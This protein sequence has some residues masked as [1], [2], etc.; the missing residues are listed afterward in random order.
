M[1]WK[2]KGK[3]EREVSFVG[4]PDG[5]LDLRM[6]RKIKEFPWHILRLEVDGT[7]SRYPGVDRIMISSKPTPKAV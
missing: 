4:N 3:G 2:V 6:Q 1:K 7:I 5:S